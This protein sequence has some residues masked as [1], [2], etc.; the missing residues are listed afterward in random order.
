MEKI[1]CR[2]G[3]KIGSLALL[4]NL[5]VNFLPT[6]K[7]VEITQTF[8][9]KNSIENILVQPAEAKKL[10]KQNWVAVYPGGVRNF[11]SRAAC[12]TFIKKFTNK[13]QNAYCEKR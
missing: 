8:D 5:G 2:E 13:G 4:M 9:Q 6:A 10:P 11:K 12:E 1:K 3:I 7:R